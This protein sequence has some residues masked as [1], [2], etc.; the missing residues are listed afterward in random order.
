MSAPS[1]VEARMRRIL[2][3]EWRRLGESVP[4]GT[5]LVSVDLAFA[6]TAGG[7]VRVGVDGD[8]FRH[9]LVPLPEGEAEVS[10]H[11]SAGVRLSTRTL[12][13]DDVSVRYADLHCLRRDLAGVFTGLAAD[14]CL[15]LNQ[16]SSRP[17]DAVVAKLR[18]WREL[19]AGQ[20]E[21]WTPQRL[22]GLY[23]ELLVLERLLA[24]R[25][26]A[27]DL[28]TGPAGEAQ[29]FRST[30]HALE[31]KATLSKEGRLVRI[32]GLDQLE[33]PAGGLLALA[34]FRLTRVPTAAGD[35]LPALIE[36][37]EHIGDAGQL[38]RRLDFLGLPALDDPLL[39][40]HG[41]EVLE[42]RWYEVGDDF[43]C[44][45]PQRLIG[46]VVP[47]GVGSVEYVV[48]LDTVA[49]ASA[50]GLEQTARMVEAS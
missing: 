20:R 16:E 26:D 1:A 29:D 27:V 42:E 46:A 44:L 35:T 19:L 5:G 28:W 25:S 31:V 22:A 48:D 43:P 24:S 36:R 7:A 49:P 40:E 17:G 45:T 21:A 6:S 34:W 38:R 41:F 18:S 3:E 10:D 2:D 13:V 30:H 9:V 37:C 14:L 39:A 11:R 23:A 33:S 32:H 12:V 50:D 4:S 15:G 8:R 47:P